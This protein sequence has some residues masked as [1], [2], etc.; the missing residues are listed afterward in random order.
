[1]PQGHCQLLQLYWCKMNV[2]VRSEYLY[3][4]TNK[5]NAKP[6]SFWTALAECA[7]RSEGPSCSPRG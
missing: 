4:T 5:Q 3:K 7:R 1:M 2:V 6:A